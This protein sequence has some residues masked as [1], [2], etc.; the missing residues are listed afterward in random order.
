MRRSGNGDAVGLG[1]GGRSGE[2]VE[3]R[4]ECGLAS[5]EGG[6]DLGDVG[7]GRGRSPVRA[8]FADL[9]LGRP[10]VLLP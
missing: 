5:V 7:Q 9:V 6:I 4:F 8:D 3:V 10:A 1:R 2:V